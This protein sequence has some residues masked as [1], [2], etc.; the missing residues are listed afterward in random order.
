MNTVK[1]LSR[2]LDGL[3]DMCEPLGRLTHKGVSWDWSEEQDLAFNKVKRSVSSAPILK[4][5]NPSEPTEG[6]GDAP[7]KGIGF[8]LLQDG[9]PVTYASRALSAAEENYARE[10]VSARCNSLPGLYFISTSYC[11]KR[12][13][14]RCSLL[15]AETSGLR[16][17]V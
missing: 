7:Q 1:Y 9:Q 16:V 6:E 14:R 8:A 17:M 4:Y 11:L 2:F 5:F 13:I 10:R 12:I 15:G 3:S